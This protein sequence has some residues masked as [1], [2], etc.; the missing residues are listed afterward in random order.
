MEF[1]Q[2]K[3]FLA[4]AERLSF[5]RGARAIGYAQSSVSAQ[6]MALEEEL[7]VRLF[8]RLGRRVR[9]TPA[10][11]SLEP[12]ARKII[13][14]EA[15]ARAEAAEESRAVGSLTVRVPETICVHRLPPV[16]AD[17]RRRMPRVKLDFIS[18]TA[19]GLRHDLQKGVTDLAFLLADEVASPDLRHEALGV[20][21]MVLVAARG[22]RLAGARAVALGE[23]AGETLL[24]SRVDC[25][26]R[27]V[28]ETAMRAAGVA[29]GLVMEYNSVAAI[30]RHA[31]AG[32]GLAFL[33]R[34]A[35]R[36]ELARGELTRLAWPQGG[37]EV[38]RL[39]VWHK[40][41]WLSPALRSFMDAARQALA[42]GDGEG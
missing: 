26:Y 3:T 35:A 4:V 23:L 38:A 5:H 18:C 9:L 14:L 6:V 30:V 31:A 16:V 32:L 2:L 33:P 12:Y 19:E 17:F 28:L 24:L 25:S 11:E 37:M 39:M 41:K 27:R 40:D 34:V 42:G 20:E 10:G 1:R 15:A 13:D 8:D 29:A 21:E 36:R 7:G 22:H